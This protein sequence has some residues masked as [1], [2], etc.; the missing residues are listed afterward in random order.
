MVTSQRLARCIMV[1]AL[2]VQAM[3]LAAKP[4]TL[5]IKDQLALDSAERD[6][7]PRRVALLGEAPTHGDGHTA[8][9]KVALVKRLIDRCGFRAVAFESRVYE[10]IA[11]NRAIRN[12]SA[13][14]AM[15]GDAVGAI[16]KNDQEVEPLFD[17]LLARARSGQ[18]KLAGLDFQSGGVGE[19][20]TNERMIMEL[21]QPLPTAQADECRAAFSRH[22]GGSR[23]AG[24]HDTLVDCAVAMKDANK[25]G[26]APDNRTRKE[27]QMMIK[28]IQAMLAASQR[29][30]DDQIRAREDALYDNFVAFT[31][32]LVPRTKIIVWGAT[33]H[34]AKDASAAW[35][36]DGFQSLGA[37]IHKS[38]EDDAL[39]LGFSAVGGSYQVF[40]KS[41]AMP[42][43]PDLALETEAFA[44]S[45]M[46]AIYLTRA[47]LRALGVRPGAALDRVYRNADWS[48]IVDGMVVFTEE[49]PTHPTAPR[50]R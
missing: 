34:L 30:E 8:A 24:D 12:R 2:A 13:T 46:S 3:P 5:G 31:D 9:F 42:T 22:P 27:R 15:V 45:E 33:T 29:S 36:L 40:G 7:C 48:T 23:N 38:Y 6:L 20:F 18:V 44:D 43:P 37:R 10:F 21:T 50:T 47:Q 16:W 19:T 25:P 11:L 49:W 32:M 4:V 35:P 17:F 28:N 14:A 41:S 26:T 39:S 1:A